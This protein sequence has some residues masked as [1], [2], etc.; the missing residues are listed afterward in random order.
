MGFCCSRP[1]KKEKDD[2]SDDDKEVEID[3]PCG[4][5]EGAVYLHYPQADQWSM[6]LLACD[7]LHRKCDENILPEDLDFD[8]ELSRI[9]QCDT[10]VFVFKQG[11]TVTVFKLD[12]LK[13]EKVT[14]GDQEKELPAVPES[15]KLPSL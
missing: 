9:I 12:K 8:L 15:T 3:Q 7:Y 2:N 14:E 10:A 5:A 1:S 13:G 4:S 6:K 11:K